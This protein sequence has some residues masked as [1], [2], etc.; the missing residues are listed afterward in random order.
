MKASN[1]MTNARMK[2]I[3][4]S[5]ANVHVR[6]TTCKQGKDGWE[7]YADAYPHDAEP[8]RFKR[9]IR[10]RGLPTATATAYGQTTRMDATAAALF[11]LAKKL[12]LVLNTD[13]CRDRA[14]AD[15]TARTAR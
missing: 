4:E 11:N 5:E 14:A 2:A 8:Y 15:F 9:H 6:V 10:Y 1:T 7:G 3:I 13:A 12:G